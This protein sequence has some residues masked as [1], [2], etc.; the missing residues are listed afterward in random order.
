MENKKKLF[1]VGGISLALILVLGITYAWLTQV[2]NGT[3]INKI[4]AG[5]LDLILDDKTSN[6]IDLQYAVPQTDSQG[7]NNQAYTFKVINNGS[8]NAKYSI[9]LEDEELENGLQRMSDSNV[10]F[11]LVKNSGESNPRLLSTV[12]SNEKRVLENN[13]VING[14]STNEYT[15][16]LWIDSEATQQEVANKVFKAK[17][18]LEAIQTEESETFIV[19]YN[20]NGGSGTMNNTTDKVVANTFTAPEGKGFKEWNTALDGTGTTYTTSSSVTSNITLY[21]IWKNLLFEPT[22][23]AFGEPTTSDIEPPVGKNFFAGLDTEGNKGVCINRNGER[24]CFE[25]NNYEFEKQHVQ[26]VF[27]DI[28]CYEYSS[29]VSCGASDFGCIIYSNGGVVCGPG[30]GN[31][32]C[33][34]A[35]NTNSVTCADEA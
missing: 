24:H 15:L 1:I 14:G 31:G 23:F 10:K 13:V 28:S 22:Y 33:S 32:G 12:V 25:T 16:R 19:T 18:K 21:A 29:F 30:S 34:V 20:A 27:S 11:D 7:L 6:G 26:E 5:T 3:K 17:I 4:T 9:Y 2:L 35:G 8:I